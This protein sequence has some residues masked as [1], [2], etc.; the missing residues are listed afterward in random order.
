[1]NSNNTIKNKD[2]MNI[3]NEDGENI[4]M[5]IKSDVIKTK[6]QKINNNQHTY[7]KK[8]GLNHFSPSQLDHRRSPDR[9]KI[10][11]FQHTKT[12][13]LQNILKMKKRF[14]AV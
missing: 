11:I 8:T 2:I 7:Q 9:I 6:K 13:I 4:E 3:N 14:Q 10:K 1:M 5:E 12:L